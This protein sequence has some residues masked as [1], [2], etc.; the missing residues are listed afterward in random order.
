MRFSLKA[1]E[2]FQ[3]D[4]G[5]R[6]P[7]SQTAGPQRV[8][9]KLTL[10]ADRRYDLKVPMMVEVHLTGIRVQTLVKVRGDK[11]FIQQT[12]SNLSEDVVTFHGMC[13]VPNAPDVGIQRLIIPEL[14]P[15]ATVTRVYRL[16]GASDLVGKTVRVGLRDRALK[17]VYNEEI[18]IP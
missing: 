3:R 12:V 11:V 14:A 8:L 4:L 2:T 13:M 9:A 10:H 5:V 6:F 16:R 18:L 7:Y 1:G 17:R 15:G